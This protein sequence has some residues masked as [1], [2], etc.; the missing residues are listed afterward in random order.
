MRHTA[1]ALAATGTA[2]VAL[3]WPLNKSSAEP[4]LA[5]KNKSDTCET[6]AAY[7]KLT[8]VRI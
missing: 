5:S 8:A 7:D 1:L 3:Q 4:T 2:L 6:A